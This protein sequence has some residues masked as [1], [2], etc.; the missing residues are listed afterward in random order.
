MS[1]VSLWRYP[2]RTVGEPVLTGLYI[3]VV[4]EFLPVRLFRSALAATSRLRL[5]GALDISGSLVEVGLVMTVFTQEPKEV[6]VISDG[7]KF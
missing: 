5:D 7:P 3:K 2:S 4:T 1:S 6:T